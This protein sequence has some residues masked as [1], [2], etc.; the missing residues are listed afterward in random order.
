MRGRAESFGVTWR[1]SEL[2][3]SIDSSEKLLKVAKRLLI[4]ASRS[5]ELQ[6]HAEAKRSS[7]RA[8]AK[9]RE[10]EPEPEPRARARARAKSQSQSQRAHN[11]LLGAM[12]P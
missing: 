12:V 4:V 2:E 7:E 9:A 8:R 3:S 10:L 5:S 6:R 11:V 1:S